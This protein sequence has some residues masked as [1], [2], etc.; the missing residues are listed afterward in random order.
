MVVLNI[1]IS[2]VLEIY[3]TTL[4]EA[5]KTSKRL[6]QASQ[7]LIAVPTYDQLKE[8]MQKAALYDQSKLN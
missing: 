8:L 6:D 1:I 7:L 4:E 2:F 5:Q 3:S